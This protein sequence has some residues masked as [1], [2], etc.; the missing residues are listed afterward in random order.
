ML[1]MHTHA[2]L[3]FIGQKRA[4]LPQYIAVLN[5]AILGDGDGWTIIDA[6][7][8]SGLLSHVAKRAKPAARVIYND[9]DGYTERL[10]NIPDINRLRRILENLLGDHPRQKHLPPA[11]KETV[12]SAIQA[13]DGYLD[14]N[15]LIS[16]LL[17]SGNQ[18]ASIDELL[19]KHM[20]HCLRQSDYP[21]AGDYLTGLEITRESY[22]TLLPRHTDDPRCLFVLDPPYVCTMQGAYCN[23]DY[24]GMVQFLRLMRHVRPPF[25]FFSST[26]S[27]LP[28]YLDFVIGEQQPGWARLAGYETL[29][30]ARTLNKA[31]RYE[32]NLIFKL[33]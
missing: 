14:L 27:E 1:K 21:E 8:G 2:P 30:F 18:A 12:V 24:F 31:A 28:A 15:C 17:F 29:K 13:F 5:R 20:Y 26:R 16:W 7:G 9:F 23:S 11:L 4:Y 33:V 22:A 6:F 19:G 32:D 25:I 10:H 3:P